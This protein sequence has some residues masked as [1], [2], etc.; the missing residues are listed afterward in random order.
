MKSNPRD[1]KK[2]VG[3]INWKEVERFFASGKLIVIND[4]LNIIDVASKFN[5][6]DSDQIG[7]WIENDKLGFVTDDQAKSWSNV[8]KE[9]ACIVVAPWVLIQKVICPD[10]K[11][12]PY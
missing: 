5:T 12:A 11:K 1:L 3:V 9:F 10:K 6:D 8:N 4:D 2:E 7:S